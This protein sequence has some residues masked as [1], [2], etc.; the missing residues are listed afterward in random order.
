MELLP[1]P[2]NIYLC[3]VKL[4]LNSRGREKLPISKINKKCINQYQANL[5]INFKRVE[6]FSILLLVLIYQK[7]TAT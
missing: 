2:L 5:R 6:C 4:S 7:G 3:Y 1:L